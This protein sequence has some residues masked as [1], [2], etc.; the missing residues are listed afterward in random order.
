MWGIIIISSILDS[1]ILECID[2]RVN[3]LSQKLVSSTSKSDQ[4]MQRLFGKIDRL[5]STA[6][7]VSYF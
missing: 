7:V 3:E 4:Q 2:N 1:D 5:T 6:N